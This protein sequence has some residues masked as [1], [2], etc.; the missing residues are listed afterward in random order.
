MT[1]LERFQDDEAYYADKKY[2]TNSALK[3]LRT[4]PTKFY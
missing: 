1:D 3:L 4:S 2:M